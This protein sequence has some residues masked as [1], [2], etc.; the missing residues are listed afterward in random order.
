MYE[1]MDLSNPV[2]VFSLISEIFPLGSMKS[3]AYNK[4]INQDK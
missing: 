1:Y 4:K 2:S 3:S